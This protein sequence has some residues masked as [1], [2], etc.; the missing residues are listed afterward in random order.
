MRTLYA[1]LRIPLALACL[2]L[3]IA[4]AIAA[5]RA[6]RIVDARRGDVEAGRAWRSLR[7]SLPLG[8][9]AAGAAVLLVRGK[10]RRRDPDR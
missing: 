1:R 3:A 4:C 6:I 5:E 9:L 7:L 8:G 10:P 2:I